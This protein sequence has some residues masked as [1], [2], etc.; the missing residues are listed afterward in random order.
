M[1]GLLDESTSIDRLMAKQ[2]DFLGQETLLQYYAKQLG[3]ESDRSPVC[4]PEIAGEGIEFNWGCSKVYY[5]AQPISR[6]RSKDKFFT[7][8]DE[9]L[10]P[11]VIPLVLCRHNARRARSYMIAYKA[12]EDTYK[13]EE[14]DTEKKDTKAT[15]RY[16]HTLIEK[17]VSLFCKR[18][19]HCN[20]ID[21]DTKYCKT[22][23]MKN[24]LSKMIKLEPKIERV[25]N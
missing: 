17:C 24:I 9:C 1:Y 21:F 3:V 23:V 15:S 22:E 6:K 2:P 5:R 4:H 19:S 20:P 11:T 14:D 12:L 8:V 25:E 10:G 18:R 7:L 16:N 13:E